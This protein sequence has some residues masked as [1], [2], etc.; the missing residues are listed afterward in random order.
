MLKGTAGMHWANVAWSGNEPFL[1]HMAGP[2]PDTCAD[3][4]WIPLVSLA[5]WSLRALNVTCSEGQKWYC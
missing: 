1:S 4:A 2:Q 5:I 3:S